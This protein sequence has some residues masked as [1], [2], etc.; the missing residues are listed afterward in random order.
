MFENLP[1]LHRK[2]RQLPLEACKEILQNA[3]YMVMATVDNNAIPYAVPL[4]FVY[5]E[6]KI[7][8]HSGMYKG[9]KASNLAENPYCSLAVIG[10]TQPV[11]T[12]NFT[13]YYESVVVFGKVCEVTDSAR[14]KAVL[15]ALAEKYLPEYMHNAEKDIT[16][17]LARTAVYEVSLDKITGKAK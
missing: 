1:E 5:F 10:K 11:Y 13:T 9:H 3:E 6:K 4:S 7:Y 16:A 15:F 12:K 17:S 8:F 2:D 14:K